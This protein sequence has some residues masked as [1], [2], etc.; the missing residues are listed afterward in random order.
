MDAVLP[1]PRQSLAA[2]LVALETIRD[3]TPLSTIVAAGSV[4]AA[5]K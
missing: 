1:T 3:Q 5:G 4:D 2:T